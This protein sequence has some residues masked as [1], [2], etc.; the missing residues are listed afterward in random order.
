MSQQFF[1]LSQ[2][3]A[4]E[5]IKIKSPPSPYQTS[6]EFIEIVGQVGVSGALKIEGTVLPVRAGQDFWLVL[7]LPRLGQQFLSVELTDENNVL[8]ARQSLPVLRLR[9]FP[10][11]K[12]EPARP[13]IEDLATLGL[14]SD[15]QGTGL[16]L[17]ERPVTRAELAVLLVKAGVIPSAETKPVPLSDVLPTHWG[18]A[19]IAAAAQAGVIGL[20]AD[21]K[22]IPEGLI[23]R[24]EAIVWLCRANEIA[25]QTV[26]SFW[27]LLEPYC[28]PGYLAAA[29]AAGLWA[30][31]W[32]K[33]KVLL[34]G[35]ITRAEVA[36]LLAKSERTSL[37]IR[38]LH[39]FNAGLGITLGQISNPGDEG[40]QP[41]ELEVKVIQPQGWLDPGSV[42]LNLPA[43]QRSLLPK[44]RIILPKGAIYTFSLDFPDSELG[45]SYVMALDKSGRLEILALGPVLF[46]LGSR[47][48]GSAEPLDLSV[49]DLW[50]DLP[51][52]VFFLA[53]RPESFFYRP[54]AGLNS[55]PQV[56]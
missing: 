55:R 47:S 18:S 30:P 9:T 3:Q 25:P 42:R 8:R 10:D 26:I 11:I 33:D 44:R 46:P 54:G 24:S 16:F 45:S 14:M 40:G 28:Q 20:N 22:F 48:S 2:A 31:G 5:V 35:P 32:Q 41:R 1:G 34:L 21:G 27:D 37:A 4:E 52:P 7:P 29:Q 53:E 23:S 51:P 56:K 36:S 17:P 39:D 6:A 43:S 50:L 49:P 13:D 12:E 15:Y 38:A 19:D